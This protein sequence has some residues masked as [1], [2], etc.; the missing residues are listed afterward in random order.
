MINIDNVYITTEQL[1]KQVVAWYDGITDRLNSQLYR[2]A[3]IDFKITDRRTT[4]YLT[5]LDGDNP[6]HVF[7]DEVLTYED[8]V[9]IYENT[10]RLFDQSKDIFKG[11]FRQSIVPLK[12]DLDTLEKLIAQYDKLGLVIE[13]EGTCAITAE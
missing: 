9:F 8:L 2:I 5:N 12:R 1:N 7:A 6:F 10:K 13:E 11:C 4:L 3:G